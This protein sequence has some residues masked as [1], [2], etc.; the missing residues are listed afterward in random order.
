MKEK[1][2]FKKLNG[3]GFMGYIDDSTHKGKQKVTKIKRLLHK[4]EIV[5]QAI[6]ENNLE[7]FMRN[8]TIELLTRQIE[9]LATE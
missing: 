4:L 1:N 2:Y 3:Y 6:P 7:R 8:C 9:E 5:T